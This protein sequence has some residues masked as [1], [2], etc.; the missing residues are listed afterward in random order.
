MFQQ[1]KCFLRPFISNMFWMV[2][3]GGTNRVLFSLF[4]GVCVYMYDNGSGLGH[5]SLNTKAPKS[6]KIS[7]NGDLLFVFLLDLIRFL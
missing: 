5:I 6:R 7:S 4:Y 3:V 1:D 2:W